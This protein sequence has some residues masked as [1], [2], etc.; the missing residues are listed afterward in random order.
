MKRVELI[1][2]A[3]LGHG[4]GVLGQMAMGTSEIGMIVAA[5]LFLAFIA[6]CFAGFH[7][8]DHE[9]RAGGGRNER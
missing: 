6:G 9:H 1:G 7:V 2:F 5:L 3:T 4:L 8:V